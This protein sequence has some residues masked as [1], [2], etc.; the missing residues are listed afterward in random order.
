[1]K[2]KLKKF[3][4]EMRYRILGIEPI[5][6]LGYDKVIIERKVKRRK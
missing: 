2:K 5:Y 1:M 6:Y 3:L 4:Q